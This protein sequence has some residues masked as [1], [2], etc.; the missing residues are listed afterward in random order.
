MKCITESYP[1]SCVLWID[2]ISNKKLYA[3][4]MQQ[5]ETLTKIYGKV[6]EFSL[7]HGTKY[8]CVDAIADEGFKAKMNITS[9]YGNG[10]YFATT[11][12]QASL[13][14]RTLTDV[15][16]MFLSDVLVG[17]KSYTKMKTGAPGEVLV[18]KMKDTCIFA[19][20]FV[21]PEDSSTYPRYIIAFHRTPSM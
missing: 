11:S 1:N 18:D 15:C 6:S 5:K 21:V 13:Y 9:V 8:D 19:C 3:T 14:M 4:Y 20:I 16:Y 17:T 12:S 7:F 10:T 2:E